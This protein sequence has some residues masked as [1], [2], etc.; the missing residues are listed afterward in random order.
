[1]EHH[2]Q[3][4][5]FAELWFSYILLFMLNLRQ[6]PLDLHYKALKLARNTRRIRV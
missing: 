3:T 4:A 6:I 2:R 1:M 5:A